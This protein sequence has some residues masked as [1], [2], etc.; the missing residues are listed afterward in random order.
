MTVSARALERGATEILHYTSEKGVMGSVMKW[1]V[2]SRERVE[3]DEELAFTYEGIWP[4]RDPDW[5]DYISLSVSRINLDLYNRSRAHYPDFWWAVMSFDPEILNH[6]GVWFTTTNNVY[7]D[8]CRRGEGV[9]GFEDMFSD[10]V[11]WGYYGSV[12]RRGEG[13]PDH[14]TTDRAA[15]VLY[16]AEL[17]LDHLCRLSVPGLQHR[18]LVNAWCEAYGRAELPIEVDP[19]AFA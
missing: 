9:D 19:G 6:D 18:R 7:D 13:T 14:W 15:E 16:P 3:G 8:V 1:K 5:I 17:S 10:E 11:L 2:L 12:F 4:R